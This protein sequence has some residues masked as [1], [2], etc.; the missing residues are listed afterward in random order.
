M[1]WVD[2]MRLRRK[3]DHVRAAGWFNLVA[4][5]TFVVFYGSEAAEIMLAAFLWAALVMALAYAFGW[6]IDKRA[7]RV[8]GH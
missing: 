6:V 1:S 8:V 5:I 4:T 7:E 3:A 2:S